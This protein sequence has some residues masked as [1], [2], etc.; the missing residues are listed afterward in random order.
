MLKYL[1]SFKCEMNFEILSPH[2]RCTGYATGTYTA[3]KFLAFHKSQKIS[4]L[5]NTDVL[6]KNTALVCQ[7][8]QENS[9][10]GLE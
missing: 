1:N 5:S 9:E 6:V 4:F 7:K 10:D 2:K 8:K 3:V